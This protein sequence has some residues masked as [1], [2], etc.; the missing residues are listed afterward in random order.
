MT[1]DEE[2]IIQELERRKETQVRDEKM[3]QA[4]RE[5]SVELR[6]LEGKLRNAYVS[7]ERA[8]QLEEKAMLRQL[9]KVPPPGALWSRSDTLRDVGARS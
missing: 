8:T 1:A 4:I 2:R 3:R 9:Q 6:Q 5:N 7:K